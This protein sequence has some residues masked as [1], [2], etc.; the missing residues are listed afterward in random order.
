MKLINHS[1]RSIGV[2]GAYKSYVL[3]PNESAAVTDADV[4]KIKENKT[5]AHWLSVGIIS[6]DN[7]VAP[8]EKSV[9]KHVG[10]GRY[11][12]FAEGVQLN[13]EPLSKEQAEAMKVEY[14]G[15]NS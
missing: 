11:S 7:S 14:D 13:D 2:M 12:V 1:A 15:V 6:L 10:R 5:C 8:V 4:K 3:A 9:V